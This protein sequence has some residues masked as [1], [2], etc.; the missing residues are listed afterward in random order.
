MVDDN[1]SAMTKIVGLSGADA[2][3]IVREVYKALYV[4]ENPDG[5][6]LVSTSDKE[7][8]DETLDA[9]GAILQNHG[10]YPGR[11]EPWRG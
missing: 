10:L 2:R 7:W 3:K 9:V 1:R 11:T 4:M 8:D 5:G 6:G